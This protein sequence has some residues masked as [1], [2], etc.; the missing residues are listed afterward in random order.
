MSGGVGESCKLASVMRRLAFRLPS[1]SGRQDEG[2]KSV[3]EMSESEEGDEMGVPMGRLSFIQVVVD[4]DGG[5][6][7]FVCVAYTT[8]RVLNVFRDCQR[9]VFVGQK[10]ARRAEWWRLI[11]IAQ[12]I[13]LPTDDLQQLQPVPLR[14]RL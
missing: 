10:V 13:S 9:G 1:F 3:E 11:G 4:M 7:H 2:I 5:V 12:P 14:C 6:N 8:L